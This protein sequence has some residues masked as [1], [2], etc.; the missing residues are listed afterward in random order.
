MLLHGFEE[1]SADLGV[2]MKSINTIAE[3]WP[4]QLKLQPGQTGAEEEFRLLLGSGFTRIERYVEWRKASDGLEPS[5]FEG[6]LW[7]GETLS[8]TNCANCGTPASIRCT[9]CA[10]APEYDSSEAVG[11]AYCNR[12]CQTTH[13]PNHKSQCN[14]MQKRKKL[15]RIATILKKTLLA[16][17]ECVFDLDIERIEFQKGSLCLQ[18]GSAQDRPYHTHFPNHLT[19]KLEY[20]EAALACNQCTLAMA[21]LGPLARHLLTG[22]TANGSNLSL[23]SLTYNRSQL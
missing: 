7:K 23:L 9:G 13:W 8:L 2:E 5:T 17:R 21:L 19:T 22:R 12:G 15:L 16:Y 14:A 3:R 20:K 18:M 6:G 4:T 11:A 10:D 1:I